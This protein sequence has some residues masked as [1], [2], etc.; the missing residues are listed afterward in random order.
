MPQVAPHQH[1]R[2]PGIPQASV[3]PLVR[4]VSQSPDRQ[5]RYDQMNWGERMDRIDRME[6]MER[7]DRMDRMNREMERED[8]ESKKY[9]NFK[10]GWKI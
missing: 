3:R 4:P 7:M 10:D 9:F 5:D 8:S 6:R 1:A 2:D